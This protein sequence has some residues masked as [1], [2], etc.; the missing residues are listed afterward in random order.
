MWWRIGKT[1]LKI[2]ALL[3][4][5]AAGGFLGANLAGVI[6]LLFTQGNSAAGVHPWTHGGWYIGTILFFIGAI[7]GQLRFTSGSARSKGSI[8]QDQPVAD[9]QSGETGAS[10]DSSAKPGKRSGVLSGALSFGFFGGLLGAIVGGSLLI[11]WF[12]LA[13]SPFAPQSV[14]ET[15]E[16]RRERNP[17]S[18][19]PQNVHRSSD[20]MVLYLCV[21]PAVLGAAAGAVSGGI[22]AA[23]GKV[24]DL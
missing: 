18:A 22:G 4:L 19:R 21:T 5:T 23:L 13:Y 20:P 16:V 10:A 1:L 8:S 3:W 6:G 14:T 17:G 15:A 2:Y 11:F 9:D 7:T 24:E 12:S